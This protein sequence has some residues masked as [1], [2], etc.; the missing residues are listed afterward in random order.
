MAF[1]S[2]WPYKKLSFE[3][4]ADSELDFGEGHLLYCIDFFMWKAS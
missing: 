4:G 3:A 2:N 1:H